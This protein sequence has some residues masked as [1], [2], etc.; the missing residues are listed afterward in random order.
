MKDHSICN[1][2]TCCRLFDASTGG[3]TVA[4]V[5]PEWGANVIAMSFQ[6]PEWAWPVPVLETVD[7][8]TI[9]GTPTSYGIPILAP[10]PGRVGRNQNGKFAYR[11]GDYLISPSRHGFLRHLKWTI[12]EQ[13]ADSVTCCVDVSSSGSQDK[14]DTDLGDANRPFPFKFHAKTRITISHRKLQCE[15]FLR[16]TGSDTQPL[17]VGWHPYLHRAGPCTV[18]IPARSRWKLDG[19]PE[20]TPTGDLIDVANDADFRNGRRLDS[21][22]HWDDIFTNLDDEAGIVSCWVEEREAILRKD[23]E[24]MST[25]IRRLVNVKSGRTSARDRGFRNIQLFTPRGRNAISLE[26]LSAPPNALNLLAETCHPRADVCE[27]D[28]GEEIR[29]ELA[30]AVDVLP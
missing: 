18:R 29:F 10:T 12:Q 28:P 26:P 5:V 24:T 30:V 19:R 8:A 6:A 14:E 13:S 27:V 25:A 16:N 15:L 11:G 21:N 23:G 2:F 3:K 17:N 22:E 9:S 4:V 1:N 20:P 7:I